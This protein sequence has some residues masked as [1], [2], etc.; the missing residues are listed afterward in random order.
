MDDYKNPNL[1]IDA[2]NEEYGLR[3]FVVFN[4]NQIKS[5]TD[6]NGMFSTEND[7]I[8][9]FIEKRRISINDSLSSEEKSNIRT[10]LKTIN[11]T[12]TT[13]LDNGEGTMYLLDHA[14]REDIE[15][16]NPKEED[17]FNCRLKFSTDGYTN[18]EIETI[19]N[20]IEDGNIRDQKSF[21]K[22]AK[23]NLDQ[24]GSDNSDS[25]DAKDRAANA[26]NDRL[27]LQTSEGK[28]RRGQ[29]NQNSQDDFRTSFI[30]VYNND[31]TNGPRYIPINTNEIL[32][33]YATPQGEIKSLISLFQS[34]V[35]P[36]VTPVPAL[37]SKLCPSPV[38]VEVFLSFLILPLSRKASSVVFPLRI[39]TS[40]LP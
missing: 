19:K 25:F 7:D 1:H 22:W 27:D 2:E 28:S 33:L 18:K 32:E 16:R 35:L 37:S 13:L 15:N 11:R 30:R 38:L 9:M 6:N 10:L 23:S 21:D 8:Q 20:E 40:T 34:S 17:G 29:S 31:G 14:D 26:D 24:Q 4:P 12:G 3:Q 36:V 39:L 5:A